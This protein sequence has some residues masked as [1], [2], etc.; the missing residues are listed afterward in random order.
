MTKAVF[1][2]RDGVVNVEKNYL[3]KI[4]DFEF[5]DG[6]F[7][8]LKKVQNLGYKLFIIT[9]Q[10]GIGR[11]YYTKEDF[12]KLTSWMLQEF[13]NNEIVISQVE[14]CPHGPN[15][16]CL[17]RKPKTGMIDKI[18]ENHNIDLENSWLVGDKSSDIKCAK[19]AG[20]LNTI[21]VKSGH[22]FNENESLAK[23]ICESIKDIDKIIQT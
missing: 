1:L 20:I 19:N 21:Q 7:D 23:Y 5:I 12:E 11:G 15:D 2:D 3:Y 14:L 13:R 10:S 4:E 17:C 9:N 8:S 22:K 6:I 16:N 18:L